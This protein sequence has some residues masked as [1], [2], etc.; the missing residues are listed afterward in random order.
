MEDNTA[1]PRRFCID[2]DR[3]GIYSAGISFKETPQAV[4]ALVH[5][6]DKA[7]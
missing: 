5:I 7:L 4:F 1:V 6:E 3:P 2:C